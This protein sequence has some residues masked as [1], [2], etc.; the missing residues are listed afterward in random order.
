MPYSRALLK[1]KRL[2]KLGY[3]ALLVK[4]YILF[5]YIDEDNKTVVLERFIHGSRDWESLILDDVKE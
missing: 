1:N 2:R 3:R 5:Y 4:D